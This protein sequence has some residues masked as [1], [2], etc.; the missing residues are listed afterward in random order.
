MDRSPVDTTKQS[1]KTR[2]EKFISGL[3]MRQLWKWLNELF[4]GDH[5]ADVAFEWAESLGSSQ[6]C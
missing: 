3:E 6:I 2:S 1:S 4:F 5:I